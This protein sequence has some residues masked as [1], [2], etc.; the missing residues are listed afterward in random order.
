MAKD[1]I[2]RSLRQDPGNGHCLNNK[3]I[4]ITDGCLFADFVPLSSLCVQDQDCEY[5]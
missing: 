5:L 3:F 1:F 4:W 2:Q